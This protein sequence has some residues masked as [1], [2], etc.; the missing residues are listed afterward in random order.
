M[1]LVTDPFT[2]GQSATARCISDIPATMIEWLHNGSVVER[3]TSTQQL[4]LVFSQVND[5]I[6]NMVYVCR[7]T[8]IGGTQEE[9]NVTVRVNGKVIYHV[10]TLFDDSLSIVPDNA[11]QASISRS[12][13]ARAGERYTLICT[14]SK[15]ISGLMNFLNVSWIAGVQTVTNDNRVTVSTNVGSTSSVSILT[16]NPLRTS[17]GRNYDCRGSLESPALT[18]PLATSEQERVNIQSS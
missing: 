3:D 12:G 10:L 4:D 5:G 9:E 6:H 8:R 7:V 13:I 17:H 1:S 16:F 15:T 18:R 2:V 11:I 14:V